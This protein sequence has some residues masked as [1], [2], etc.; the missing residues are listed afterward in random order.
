MYTDMTGDILLQHQKKKKK[1]I[2]K[3]KVLQSPINIVVVS[4]LLK[5]HL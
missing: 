1:E 3:L 2:K 4:N 5:R